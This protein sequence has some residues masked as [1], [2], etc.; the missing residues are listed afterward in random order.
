MK[1]TAL[2]CSQRDLLDAVLVDDV[3]VRHLQRLG[4]DQVQLLLARPP[5]ALALLNRD[6]GRLHAVADR[7][8]QRLALGGLEDMVVLDVPAGGLEIAVALLARGRVAVV[9]D[10]ELELRGHLGGVAELP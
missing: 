6:A 3:P 8:H 2:P 7:P 4:I 1:L 10:V 9:E 5:L